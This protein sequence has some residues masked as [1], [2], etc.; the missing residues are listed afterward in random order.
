VASHEE[1]P[2]E[3]AFD[4]FVLYHLGTEGAFFHISRNPDRTNLHKI[5]P[6]K[7]GRVNGSIILGLMP[8]G[9]GSVVMFLDKRAARQYLKG[10]KRRKGE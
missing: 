3:A 1:F 9:A 6:M 2:A 7:D 5:L 8:Q 10:A 4:R